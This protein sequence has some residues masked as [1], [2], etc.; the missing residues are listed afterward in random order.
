MA[1]TPE[2]STKLT[3][4]TKT[5]VAKAPPAKPLPQKAIAQNTW[6]TKPRQ[7]VKLDAILGSA[8]EALRANRMRAFLTMLGVIIGVSAVIA[9]VSLTQGVN[10]SVSAR[11]ASLRSN[12]ITI[13][14]GAASTN[15][16][17]SAAGTEQTLTMDDAQAVGQ[18]DHVVEM[19]PL[20]S[21]SAQ[22]V[23]GSQNW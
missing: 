14:P 9:V 17:R 22:V 6:Y 1:K 11:F 8:L 5:A 4:A 2:P 21:T 23:Y 20:L 15:G 7:G 10:Q 19:T 16:A 13:S 18:L 12:V 3:P